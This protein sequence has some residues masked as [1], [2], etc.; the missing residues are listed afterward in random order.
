MSWATSLRA[1]NSI[2]KSAATAINDDGIPT[3]QTLDEVAAAW[4][5]HGRELWL[6]GLR[7][8]VLQGLG[9]KDPVEF[10][11]T[12]THALALAR[13]DFISTLERNP[14]AMRRML[15]LLVKTVRHST[16][17]L[18]DLVFLDLPGRVKTS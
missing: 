1:S 3:R 14:D 5:R 17:H 15:A 2:G 8:G 18:E 13:Q 10:Q 9:V 16:G 7:Q 4:R 6:V 12:E 11:R